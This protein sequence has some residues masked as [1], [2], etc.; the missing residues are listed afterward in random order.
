MDLKKGLTTR[1][2]DDI[3]YLRDKTGLAQYCL[4]KKVLLDNYGKHCIQFVAD[5]A[6]GTLLD[7][8]TSEKK[9]KGL[10]AIKFLN[11]S[12]TSLQIPC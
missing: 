2:F 4:L 5:G 11:L 6:L 9:E 3:N 7:K 8:Q 1:L 10:S 12:S